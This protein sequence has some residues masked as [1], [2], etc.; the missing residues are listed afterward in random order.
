MST[1]S[2]PVAAMPAE[3]TDKHVSRLTLKSQLDDMALLWPWVE[4]LI[5]Q[6]AIP[7]DT[8]FAI[9]LCLEEAIS[10]VIR[11]GYIGQANQILTVNCAMPE[12]NLVE[13]TI[14]DQ[15]PP[16]DPLEPEHIEELDEPS[17]EDFLRPGG[18]GIL[19]MRKFAS[20]IKYERIE[21][22]KGGG[23]RLTIGF[24]LP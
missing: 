4:A 6:Y 8:A 9:H 10:N 14:E 24:A 20:T 7:S 22:G 18:R 16:F 12:A 5:A 2:F 15:A 17:P 23:N 21:T 11:H 13:F 19:L 3:D 1:I